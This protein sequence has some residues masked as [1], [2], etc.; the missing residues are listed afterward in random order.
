MCVQRDPIV[1][2]HQCESDGLIRDEIGTMVEG[3]AATV[4][5]TVVILSR[6][7]AEKRT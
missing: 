6:V 2:W 7:R 4:M 3:V 5:M 1:Y